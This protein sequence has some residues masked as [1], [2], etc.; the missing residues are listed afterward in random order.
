MSQQFTPRKFEGTTKQKMDLLA[1]VGHLLN[2]L[3][4]NKCS[5]D[6]DWTADDE[7]TFWQFIS[8][9]RQNDQSSV[10]N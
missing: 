10:I 5:F 6:E 8:L 4:G 3:R 7:E 9:L 1:N 2:K